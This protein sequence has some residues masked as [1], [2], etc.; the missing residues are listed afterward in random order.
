[1]HAY[2][3]FS[4]SYVATVAL[5]RTTVIFGIAPCGLGVR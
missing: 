1:M 4:R 3:D 2:G 5:K